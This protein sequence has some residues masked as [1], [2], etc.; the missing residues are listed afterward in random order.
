MINDGHPGVDHM[1]GIALEDHPRTPNL[2]HT[3]ASVTGVRGS[4]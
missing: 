1:I 4:E 2:E 3:K